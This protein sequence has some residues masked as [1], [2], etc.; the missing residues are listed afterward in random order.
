VK[1]KFWSKSK[2]G[3]QRSG[4]GRAQVRV[5]PYA[6]AEGEDLSAAAE[7]LLSS[8][9]GGDAVAQIVASLAAQLNLAA[10]TN[11]SGAGAEG[12]KT[13]DILV[14]ALTDADAESLSAEAVGR[15]SQVTRSACVMP[16]CE[17]I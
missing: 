1:H 3:A 14:S 16:F 17:V 12:L 9:T 13:R 6:P 7:Q 4:A 2:N 8:A 11:A 5:E 10:A 15:T